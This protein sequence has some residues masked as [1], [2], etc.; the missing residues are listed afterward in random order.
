MPSPCGFTSKGPTRFSVLESVFGLK[1]FESDKPR[2]LI[3]IESLFLAAEAAD[4]LADQLHAAA[5]AA[6]RR[7][8]TGDH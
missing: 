5:Q 6:R 8:E 4:L 7:A 2:S 1:N 3:K